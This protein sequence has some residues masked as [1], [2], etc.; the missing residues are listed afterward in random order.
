MPSVVFAAP[1]QRTMQ[2]AQLAVQAMQQHIKILPAD[3]FSEIDYGPDENKPEAEVEMRLGRDQLCKQGL[4]PD[5]HSSSAVQALGQQ[6]IA[7]WNAN[8]IVPS[9]WVVDVA[10]CRQAW[11]DFAA[12]VEKSYQNQIVMVVSSNGI[13]RFAPY[14]TADFSSFTAQYNIKVATGNLCVFAKQTTDL[15]WH[16]NGWDI[17]PIATKSTKIGEANGPNN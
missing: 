4:S 17:N 16:C 9:G 8:A 6:V 11:L 2:T 5:E 15:A 1:L 14:L 10:A 7:A 3:Q 13:M 12:M